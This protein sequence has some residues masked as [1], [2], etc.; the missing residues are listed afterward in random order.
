MTVLRYAVPSLEL[1]CV[2]RRLSQSHLEEDVAIVKVP[3]GRAPLGL[4]EDD[5]ARADKDVV[6]IAV[7]QAEVVDQPPAVAS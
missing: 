5:T 7:A 2:A 4:D 3:R 6:L 1:L